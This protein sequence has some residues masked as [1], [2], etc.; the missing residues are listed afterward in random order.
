MV[1]IQEHL[2]VK[3]KDDKD[4]QVHIYR[5]KEVVTRRVAASFNFNK[6]IYFSRTMVLT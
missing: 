6:L 4:P 2:L 3:Q 5:S 1:T